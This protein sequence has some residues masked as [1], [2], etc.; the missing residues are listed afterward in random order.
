MTPTFEIIEYTSAEMILLDKTSGK[1]YVYFGCPQSAYD[2]IKHLLATS[3]VIEAWQMLK[4]Y[5]DKNR[6][7]METQQEMI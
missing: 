4:P 3:R 1:E 7:E 6:I 2:N 5:G